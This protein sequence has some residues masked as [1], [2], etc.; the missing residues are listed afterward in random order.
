MTATRILSLTAF[1]MALGSLVPVFAQENDSVSAVE[2]WREDPT[3]I[4][5][6]TEIDLGAFRWIARPVVV[7]A[8]APQ[9]PAFQEQMAYIEEDIDQLVRRD[10]VIVTDTDPAAMTD[11]RRE[12]R[13][14]GFQL[15]LIGKDGDVALRKPFPWHM[16]ELSRSIDK[17]PV[18]QRE[19]REGS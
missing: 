7:F 2:R 15:T 19:I 16:R 13:P 4:F 3:T 17:M 5:D 10:V 11:L 18:R 12:L 9:M 8:E 6:A 1:L 14:R